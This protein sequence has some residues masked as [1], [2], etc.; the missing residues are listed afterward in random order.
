MNAFA[1]VLNLFIGVERLDEHPRL[2][3]AV[4][5]ARLAKTGRIESIAR[6]IKRESF[7]RD[8]MQLR[9]G[10]DLIWNPDDPALR[11]YQRKP[12]P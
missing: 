11:Q 3:V 1:L 12:R 8:S 9:W 2:T 10:R 4:V 6:A 7:E 5:R